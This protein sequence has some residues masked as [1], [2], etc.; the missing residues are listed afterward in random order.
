MPSTS[1]RVQ[2]LGIFAADDGEF[3]YFRPTG[4]ALTSAQT[5]YLVGPGGSTTGGTSNQGFQ[6]E[7]PVSSGQSID[8]MVDAADPLSL[9]VQ[10]YEDAL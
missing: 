2:L 7:L 8:Y 4:S 1:L 3:A 5:P 10:G 9:F 6:Y